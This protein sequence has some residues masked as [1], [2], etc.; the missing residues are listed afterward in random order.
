MVAVQFNPAE[1][2]QVISCGQDKSFMASPACCQLLRQHMHTLLK[3]LVELDHGSYYCYNYNYYDLENVLKSH[4]K[5]GMLQVGLP[6]LGLARTGWP[7]R[8]QSRAGS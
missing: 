1:P 3:E 5:D 8:Q 7:E 4:A 2:G 6:R